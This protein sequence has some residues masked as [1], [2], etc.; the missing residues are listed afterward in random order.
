MILLDTWHP[1]IVLLHLFYMFSKISA[2]FDPLV[3]LARCL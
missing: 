3:G 1:R 2:V